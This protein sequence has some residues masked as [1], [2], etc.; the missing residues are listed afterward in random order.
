MHKI[1]SLVFLIGI[2]TVIF[3]SPPVYCNTE[4]KNCSSCKI[5]FNDVVKDFAVYNS[6]IRDVYYLNEYNVTEHAAD[7]NSAI[8]YLSQGFSPDLASNIAHQY[9]KWIPE[10]EQLSVIP[11]DSIPLIAENDRHYIKLEWLDEDH[12][13][14]ERSYM[15]CYEIGDHYIYYIT[16][17][18]KG[19]RWI[20]VD[21]KLEQQ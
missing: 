13:I 17:V 8:E 1:C 16:C 19:K 6:L 20:I 5:I 3:F 4:T 11:T 15:D 21:L 7:I 10:I 14:L 2:F 18:N 9:L 12:V